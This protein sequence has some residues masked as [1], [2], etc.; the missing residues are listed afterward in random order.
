MQLFLILALVIAIVIVLF[1]VQNAAMV[2]VSF[3]SFYFQGSLAFI[4]VIVFAAGFIAGVS[5]TLPSVIKKSFVLREQK[6]KLRA[7]EEKKPAQ[8]NPPSS[9]EPHNGG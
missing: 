9:K 6:R 1:A 5:V 3:L 2:T 8:T 7:L 4:L